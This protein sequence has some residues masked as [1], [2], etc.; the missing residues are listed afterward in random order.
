MA[1][2]IALVPVDASIMSSYDIAGK[3]GG[4]RANCKPLIKLTSG[5]LVP[6]AAAALKKLSD[7]V[8]AAG[9]DFRVTDCHREVSIQIAL[10]K[11]Y[12]FWV[13]SG[14]PKGAAYN[15]KTMKNAFVAM[16]GKSNHNGGRAVDIDI[17][18]LKFAGVPANLQLDKLWEIASPLGWSHIIK[19]AI[20]GSSESW[21][22]DFWGDIDGLHD[23]LGYEQGALAGALLVGQAGNW[24]TYERVIQALVCRAGQNIGEIDGAI[25]A[26]TKAALETLFKAP[27]GSMDARLKAKD[28]SLFAPLVAL[29]AFRQ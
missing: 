14:K 24:Q 4:P 26:K 21:H 1:F 3:T 27:K 7:A 29:P 28:E 5:K 10:R 12:D 13:A 17:G 9:G 6:A 18:S 16:P 20:E 25:G 22:F 23:R 15:S 11:R 2:P 8:A 19:Y